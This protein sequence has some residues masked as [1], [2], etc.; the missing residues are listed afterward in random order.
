M[1]D[2]FISALRA[3]LFFLVCGFLA[4]YSVLAGGVN[5]IRHPEGLMGPINCLS[6][7]PHKA[8]ETVMVDLAIALAAVSL[9]TVIV[10]FGQ[11]AARHKKGER[12]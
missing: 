2:V 9:L 3:A 7:A 11:L 12:T 5:E 1:S 4:A 8:C 6:K 10:F